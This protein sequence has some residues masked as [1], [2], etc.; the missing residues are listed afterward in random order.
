MPSKSEIHNR[1]GYHRATADS[2]PKHADV[3]GHFEAF[4]QWVAR[5]LPDGRE[6]SLALTA[7]QE[8]MMWSNAAIAMLNDVDDETPDLPNAPQTAVIDQQ[9]VIKDGAMY[10]VYE[11]GDPDPTPMQDAEH[12]WC[13]EVYPGRLDDYTSAGCTLLEGHDHPQHVAGD[14]RRI[15]AVWDVVQESSWT[16]VCGTRYFNRDGQYSGTCD[17]TRAQHEGSA[18]SLSHEFGVKKVRDA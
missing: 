3:R 8:A 12:M 4:A 10:R 7:L 15:V 6:Q 1:F 14:G 18:V 5:E 11:A 16:D 13:S 9:G 17:L 2:A